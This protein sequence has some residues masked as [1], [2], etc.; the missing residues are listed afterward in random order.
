MATQTIKKMGKDTIANGFTI[1]G[2]FSYLMEF[3]GEITIMVLLT[4][5]LLNLIRIWD[6]F[7]NKKSQ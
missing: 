5:L 1:V 3:Q 7:K 2:L 4:G 6:R